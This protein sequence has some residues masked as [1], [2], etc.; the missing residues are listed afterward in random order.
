MSDVGQNTVSSTSPIFKSPQLP[1]EEN[2][3]P[4]FQESSIPTSSQLNDSNEGYT[5]N[6]K[7]KSTVWEHFTK[8]KINNEWKATC[9][10]C[11]KKLNGDSKN[12]TSHLREHLRRCNNKGQVGIRQQVLLANV[13]KSDGKVALKTASFNQ[14]VS[15]RGLSKLIVMHEY[16]LL[17]VDHAQFKKYCSSL[18]PLFE[19]PSRSTIKRDILKMFKEEKIKTMSNLE[20]NE[21]RIAITTDM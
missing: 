16:P 8:E 2:L 15:R 11:K 13:K 1:S 18:Q 6:S 10:H 21:G 14:D 17:T 9:N 5:T 19:M 12:G 4:S 3:S 20:A 7:L